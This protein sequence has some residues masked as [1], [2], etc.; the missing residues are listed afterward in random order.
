MR[1]ARCALAAFAVLAAAPVMAADLAIEGPPPSA[2]VPSWTGFYVGLQGG[3]ALGTSNQIAGGPL[4]YGPTTPGYHT[5]G[6]LFGGIA[7]YNWQVNTVVVGI[8]GDAAWADIFGQAN[9][10]AP[11]TTTSVNGTRQDWLATERVRLGFTP[12]N[13]TL[14][15][16]TG[17]VAES[18]VEMQITTTTA[19]LTETHTRFGGVFGGG[20]ENMIT[21][22][23]S[24]KAE[25]LYSQASSHAYLQSPPP[26]FNVRSDIPIAD[27]I[28]RLGINYRFGG[29]FAVAY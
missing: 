18:G 28:F 11:F 19:M 26:T 4:G 20:F 2:P 8:E 10:Q 13:N 27:N 6:A 16:L 5:T 25:Y 15:Y 29:P 9:E 22:Q 7:G 24:V 23:W 12:L 21:P 1:V 3:G 14:F 17:G